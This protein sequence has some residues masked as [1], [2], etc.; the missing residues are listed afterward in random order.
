LESPEPLPFSEDITLTLK[1]RIFSLSPTPSRIPTELVEL[2]A[3]LDFVDNKVVGTI[4]AAGVITRALKEGARWLV[5]SEKVGDGLQYNIYDMSFHQARQGYSIQVSGNVT[6]AVRSGTIDSARS[7]SPLIRELAG[8]KANEIALM[9]DTG[10]LIIPNFIPVN[11]V[12][13]VT[14][15]FRV[16]SNGDETRALIIPVDE[17]GNESTLTAG[18]Y[19]LEF[20]LDRV[21]YRSQTPDDIS[22]YRAHAS[23]VT[24]W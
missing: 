7:T 10:R 13:Y 21:R 8:M 16:L 14:V 2:A 22:N 5:R 12:T 11:P 3:G 18:T 9:D 20:D 6:E 24:S 19:R 1:K 15:P 23:I 17:L 4:P